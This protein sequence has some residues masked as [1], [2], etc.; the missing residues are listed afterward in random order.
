MQYFNSS[1]KISGAAILLFTFLAVGFLIFTG[2]AE[3]AMTLFSSGVMMGSLLLGVK[4][5]ENIV[6]KLKDK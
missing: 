2:K 6:G 4:V 3:E 1:S 5:G